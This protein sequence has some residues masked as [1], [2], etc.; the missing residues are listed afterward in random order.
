MLNRYGFENRT[1]TC[2]FASAGWKGGGAVKVENILTGQQQGT[3]V[4][5]WQASVGPH[6][7]AMIKL[8]PL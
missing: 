8:S 4:G 5:G 2:D 6:S 7:V 3:H 1:L